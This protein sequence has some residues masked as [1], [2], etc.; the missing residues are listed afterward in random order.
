MSTEFPIAQQKGLDEET[1]KSMEAVEQ[2]Y[3][4]KWRSRIENEQPIPESD[5]HYSKLPDSEKELKQFYG[6][7]DATQLRHL[8]NLLKECLVDYDIAKSKIDAK[9]EYGTDKCIRS[10]SNS[11]ATALVSAIKCQKVNIKTT[12]TTIDTLDSGTIYSPNSA[13]ATLMFV[14]TGTGTSEGIAEPEDVI[15]E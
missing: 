15:I 14:G 10:F 2:K 1:L 12:G 5:R 7:A 4:Y 8:R 9:D 6:L 13:S 11:L 3:D